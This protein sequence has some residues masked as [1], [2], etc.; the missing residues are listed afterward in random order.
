MLLTEPAH[1]QQVL[2]SNQANYR[3]AAGFRESCRPSSNRLLC[4][5]RRPLASQHRLIRPLFTTECQ[6]VYPDNGVVAEELV[7]RFR[8]A[9]GPIDLLSEMKWATL[10]IIGRAMFGADLDAHASG[11]RDALGDMRQAFR[12]RADPRG[13]SSTDQAEAAFRAPVR[14]RRNRPRPH[15]GT[16]VE[17]LEDADDLLTRLLEAE[18]ETGEQMDDQQ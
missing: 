14:A 5:R 10:M 18:D 3:K 15:R 13:L 11:I 16:V 17:E 12:A 6:I 2:E 7:D 4:E 8:A 9:R 1:I